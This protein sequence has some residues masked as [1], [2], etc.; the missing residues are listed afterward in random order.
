MGFAA[1]LLVNRSGFV[2]GINFLTKSFAYNITVIASNCFGFKPE[3]VKM[4]KAKKEEKVEKYTKSTAGDYAVVGGVIAAALAG[5]V[6]WLAR[7]FGKN[8]Q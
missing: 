8:S 3:G 1:G 4:S 7:D 6:V 5:A 2:F